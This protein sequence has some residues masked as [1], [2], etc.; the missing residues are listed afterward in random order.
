MR[1]YLLFTLLII[2]FSACKVTQNV[3]Y[4]QS[5]SSVFD[6]FT[7]GNT[8]FPLVS[9]HRGGGEPV[10]IPENCIESFEFYAGRL[11]SIIECDIVMSKD[12]VLYM[13]H[14]NTLER[15]TTGV[16]NV[17][18]QNWDN[19]KNLY[20]KDNYGNITPYRVPTLEQVLTWG[21]NRVLFTLDV[22]KD[23]PFDKVVRL[24]EKTRS[25]NI[26]IVITYNA[27]DAKKVYDLNPNLLISVGIMQK[28]DY[29][30]LRDYGI[31]DKN[32]VAFIGTRE[33]DKE[34]IDFLHQ[35]GILTILGVLGNLDKKA[36]TQGDFLYKKYLVMGVDIL[37]T[38]RPEAVYAEIK[39]YKFER[40]NNINKN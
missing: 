25:E 12:S 16:G 22:K 33:P 19:V 6:F 37:S 20:V 2:S 34:L 9:V 5:P 36:A 27:T 23:T 8:K 13:M 18:H 7:V 21:K 17:Y 1:K 24:I 11:P 38:D 26:S 10:N 40:E 3:N 28:E 4:V 29:F 31:P 39:N 35:K 15:T 30:R 32:M 14:D